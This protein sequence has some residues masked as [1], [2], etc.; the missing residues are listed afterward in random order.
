MK[1]S[2]IVCRPLTVT[3]KSGLRS[4]C[5]TAFTTGLASPSLPSANGIASACPSF[6]GTVVTRA[7]PAPG[8]RRRTFAAV[9]ATKALNCGWSAV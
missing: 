4:A 7:E 9:R 3:A 2:L 6:E 8:I 5:R 1:S